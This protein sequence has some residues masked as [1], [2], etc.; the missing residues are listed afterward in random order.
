MTVK[1]IANDLNVSGRTVRLWAEKG[2]IKADMLV[3]HGHLKWVV[4]PEDY[5]QFLVGNQKYLRRSLIVNPD[6]RKKKW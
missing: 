6:R 3:A 4:R 5:M 1:Q 2:R